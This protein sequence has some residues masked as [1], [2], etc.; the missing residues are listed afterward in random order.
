MDEWTEAARESG[1]E[2]I[3]RLLAKAT[4]EQA[5]EAILEFLSPQDFSKFIVYLAEIV[6]SKASPT[7]VEVYGDGF[8]N[9]HIRRRGTSVD[10]VPEALVNRRIVAASKWNTD[11]LLLTL[12]EKAEASVNSEVLLNG[13]PGEE[14]IVNAAWYYGVRERLKDWELIRTSVGVAVIRRK[15]RT[16]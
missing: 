3:E 15:E 7:T 9:L 16:Q 4:P 8:G 12:E 11:M 13:S 5:R 6:A 2:K 10:L 1:E 14:K